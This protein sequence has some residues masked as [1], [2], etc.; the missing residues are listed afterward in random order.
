MDVLDKTAELALGF[1]GTTRM[2]IKKVFDTFD[3]PFPCGINADVLIAL[4]R[5]HGRFLQMPDMVMF[6]ETVNAPGIVK[7]EAGV[8]INPVQWRI[9]VRGATRFN[10]A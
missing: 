5:V 9:Q 4:Q 10:E 2:R 8:E 3:I 6:S 1:A 7:V